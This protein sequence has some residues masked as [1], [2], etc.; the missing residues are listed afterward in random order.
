MEHPDSRRSPDPEPSLFDWIQQ[1]LCGDLLHRPRSHVV[2]RD[3]VRFI[4]KFQQYT[5]PVMAK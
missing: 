5:S 2:R 3:M 4:T 1:I